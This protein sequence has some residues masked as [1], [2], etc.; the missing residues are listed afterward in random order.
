MFLQFLLSVSKKK[1]KKRKRKKAITIEST[2]GPLLANGFFDALS[3]IDGCEDIRVETRRQMDH[4]IARKTPF[5]R[6][7]F[8]LSL[9]DFGT[10]LEN[11]FPRAF[12]AMSHPLERKKEGMEGYS[13][14]GVLACMSSQ[15]GEPLST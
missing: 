4:I 13:G 1:K 7:P 14:V 9:S 15:G 11:A 6:P 3:P 5:S 8:S 2:H 12:H 10:A